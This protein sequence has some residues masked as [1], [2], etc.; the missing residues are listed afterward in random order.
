MPPSSEDTRA[1]ILA[2]AERQFRRIGYAKTTVADI[3]RALGMSPAN[4]YRFFA[5]KSAINEAICADQLAEGEALARR[6]ARRQEPAGV[7]LR[8]FVC[9]IHALH[10][11][12]FA[13][14]RNLHELVVTAMTQQW[15]SIDQYKANLCAVLVHIIA[16]G[17]AAG[18]YPLVDAEAPGRVAFTALAKVFNPAMIAQNSHEDLA[19][20]AEALGAFLDSALRAGVTGAEASVQAPASL[21][22]DG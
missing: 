5:S 13:K 1:R 14:E 3:A 9:E 4:V 21:A 12:R 22:A 20:Q 6:I 17:I 19:E 15:R 10:R 16:D 18:E 2:E 11:E 7:R 8:A